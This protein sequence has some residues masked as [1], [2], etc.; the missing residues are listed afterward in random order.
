MGA[1]DV[2]PGV[3]GGTIAFI[4]GIYEELIASL[5]RCDH[6]ALTLLYREGIVAAWRHIN[7]NFLF[8]LLAGIAFSVFSLANVVSYCLEEWP[9]QVWSFFFGLVL[10]ASIHLFRQVDDWTPRRALQAMV[11]LAVAIMISQLRPAELP[12]DWWVLMA[13]GA[14]AI[15]AMLLPG[16]SGGFLLL[17]MG[18]YPIVIKA[19][20]DLNIPVLAVFA[21]GCGVG[22]LTFSHLLGWLLHKYHEATMAVLT[23]FLMGSLVMLWPWRVTV[24]S[25]MD[26]HG[27]VRPLVDSVISPWRYEEIMNVS[28]GLP[29]AILFFCLGVILVLGTEKLQQ[30]K[31]G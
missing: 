22:L 17:I 29:W 24:E 2:V 13:G 1:A 5:R 4:T 31:S 30:Q 20:G 15:S 27:E 19:V 26:R 28:S 6:H 8:T 18:L 23:G 25:V 9:I 16:I 11:G 21:A 12:D 10:A 3:S 14:V 7:G